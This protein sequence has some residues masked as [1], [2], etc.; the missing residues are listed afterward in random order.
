MDWE[1]RDGVDG[2]L[3]LKFEVHVGF[4]V[5][6]PCLVGGAPECC[7]PAAGR[8][9]KM[10]GYSSRCDGV[11]LAASRQPRGTSAELRLR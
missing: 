8:R 3:G 5:R 1:Y 11:V 10:P 4:G 9:K 7:L 6:T 2:E